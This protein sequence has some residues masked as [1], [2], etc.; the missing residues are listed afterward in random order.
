LPAAQ[1]SCEIDARTYLGILEMETKQE[2]I[3]L[4]WTK[5][6]APVAVLVMMSGI[7]TAQSKADDT[8][9][10][11]P[12]ALTGKATIT[13]TVLDPDGKPVADAKVSLL[14]PRARHHKAAT[15]EPDATPPTPKKQPPLQSGITGADGTFALTN[16]PN[17]DFIVQARLK[18][19]G[20]G[21]AKVTV[22]DDKDQTVSV[23]LK[24]RKKA[25]PAPN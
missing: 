10:T 18:G 6:V 14:P 7:K 3:M 20:N 11:T 25:A 13:V 2:H 12:P 1:I 22:A 4:R 9:P 16:V 15:T 24:A 21:T 8:A 19:T 17:G 5:W 23:T